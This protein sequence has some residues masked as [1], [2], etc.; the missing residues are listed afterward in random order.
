MKYTVIAVWDHEGADDTD[1][2]IAGVIEGGHTPVDQQQG[3]FTRYAVT[4]EADSP[5]AAEAMVLAE[6]GKT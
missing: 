5:A 2:I 4:V 3:P 6:A 1:L